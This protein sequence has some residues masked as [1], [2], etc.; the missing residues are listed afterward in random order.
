MPCHAILCYTILYYIILCYDMLCYV[1]F[2]SAFVFHY[3][4]LITLATSYF[5]DFSFIRTKVQI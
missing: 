1:T 3:I 2:F 4:Y 5:A